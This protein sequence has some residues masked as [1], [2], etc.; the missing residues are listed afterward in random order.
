MIT[1][2][3]GPVS[4][5]SRKVEIVLYEKSLPFR[6][7]IVPFSQTRGYFDRPAEV[8]RIHPQRQVPVLIDRDVELY[9]SSIIAEYLD[10]AYPDPPL[11]PKSPV[12]RAHCRLWD[13]FGDEVMLEPIRKLM[14]RTE[15]HDHAGETW[16]ALER[17]AALAMPA[18]GTHFDRLDRA[19]DGRPFLGDAFSLADIA[20]VMAV[21]WSQRLAGPPFGGRQ[22]LSAWYLRLRDRPSVAKAF[23][24]ISLQDK[25]LSAPVAG[26]NGSA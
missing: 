16:R 10:E 11:M 24:E 6:Q 14:H 13:N 18:I 22:H 8:V 9:D 5:F 1:I 23:A 2:Y 3:S 7:V 26:A 4:W 12:A 25:W 19:L 17:D 15:P 20:C 21:Y